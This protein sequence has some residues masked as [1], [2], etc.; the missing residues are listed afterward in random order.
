MSDQDFVRISLDQFATR[1]RQC[2]MVA[3]KEQNHM[4]KNLSTD[5]GPWQAT[6]NNADAHRK[7]SAAIVEHFCRFQ[8]KKNNRLLENKKRHSREIMGPSRC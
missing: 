7:I 4:F 1:V 8:M 5:N 2:D 3:A 6:D